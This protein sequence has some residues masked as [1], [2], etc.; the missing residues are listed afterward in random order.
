VATFFQSPFPSPKVF[1]CANEACYRHA[2]GRGGI[3]KAISWWD[4]ALILSPRGQNIT[5]ITHELTHIEFH[6][7]LG[8]NIYTS[9]PSWFDEG[10]AA[11]V[12]DDRRYLAPEGTENRCLVA[13]NDNLPTTNSQWWQ[14]MS[15]D[16]KHAYAQA[17]CR[18]VKWMAANGGQAGLLKLVRNA[19]SGQEFGA[20]PDDARSP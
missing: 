7:L 14:Q 9:V 12:S 19:K 2:E 3:S 13:E 10:L 4:K 17:T 6:H 16:P 8:A 1:I 11:Y 5:I 20:K 18:V 15:R